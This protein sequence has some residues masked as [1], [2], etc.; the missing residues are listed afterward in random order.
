LLW[1]GGVCGLN[2][3]KDF[4]PNKEAQTTETLV[5]FSSNT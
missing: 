5:D 1:V 2:G 4:A 3:G